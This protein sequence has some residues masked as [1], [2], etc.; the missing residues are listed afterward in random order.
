MDERLRNTRRVCV[1]RDRR[2]LTREK[3]P[4]RPDKLREM[5]PRCRQKE[6]SA[7]RSRYRLFKR[8]PLSEFHRAPKMTSKAKP[9][10]PA[11]A[12]QYCH[13]SVMKNQ[14]SVP[15]ARRIHAYEQPDS[16]L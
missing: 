2:R 6:V 5:L 12:N 14:P 16:L 11:E 15:C 1:Q 9:A 4:P 8:L 7:V 3:S 13:A 10:T